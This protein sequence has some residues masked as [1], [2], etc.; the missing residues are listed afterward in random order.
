MFTKLCD[1]KNYIAY[2]AAALHNKNH[3]P[4]PSCK[5]AENLIHIALQP[6]WQSGKLFSERNFGDKKI[7]E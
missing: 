7:F 1:E 3:T 2:N 4:K 6:M 5:S